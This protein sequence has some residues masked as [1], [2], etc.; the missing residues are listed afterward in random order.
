MTLSVAERLIVAADFKPDEEYGVSGARKKVLALATKLERTG[1]TLKVNSVLRACGYTLID[2]IH[3]CRL[4]VF[5]DLK[6]YDIGETLSTDGMFLRY[7]KPEL[8]TVATATG[9][10]AM[11][12]LKLELPHTEVLGVTVLTT[13]TDEDSLAMF[14]CTTEEAVYR[15]A[16]LA[17]AAGLDGLISSPKE[18]TA[19]SSRYEHLFTINTPA[20]RPEWSVVEG[21]DQNPARV[22]TPEKALR[23]GATRIVVGRPITQSPDPYAAVMRTLDEMAKVVS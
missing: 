10:A 7:H 5:A 1:V 19:L 6:L 14:T 17:Q 23:A 3:E 12:S 18:A 11:R 13:F 2:Q 4:R 21:D 15:F 22:M 20:I 8:L 9:E 16:D